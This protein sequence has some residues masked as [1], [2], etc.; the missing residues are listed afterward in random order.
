MPASPGDKLC[1]PQAFL[2][3]SAAKKPYLFRRTNLRD[4]SHFTAQSGDTT[5]S[6]SIL[7]QSITSLLHHQL[8]MAKPQR[9]ATTDA[10]AP[11]SKK[12]KISH[13]LPTDWTNM[14]PRKGGKRR[15][16]FD[17]LYKSLPR[18][19]NVIDSNSMVSDILGDT[20]EQLKGYINERC[21]GSSELVD[22]LFW[23]AEHHPEHLR[24][25]ELCETLESVTL[26]GADINS[27]FSKVRDP[28]GS[29]KQSMTL[30]DLLGTTE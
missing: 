9:A 12:K 23:I 3:S 25:K 24:T 15:Q 20:K 5:T 18:S 21:P 6:N 7:N 13:H 1:S 30:Y 26:I 11:P 4:N 22:A 8:S 14:R 27:L 17:E 19:A 28:T 29:R 2:F 16:R 10:A